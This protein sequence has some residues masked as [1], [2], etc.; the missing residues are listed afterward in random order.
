MSSGF[1]TIGVSF[2]NDAYDPGV[3]DRNLYIDR[4]SIISPPGVDKPD[5]P[6]ELVIEAEDASIRTAGGIIGG[7]WCLWS[8]GTLGEYVEIPEAGIYVVVVR[9]YGSPLDSI[10]PEMALTVDAVNEDTVTVDNAEYTDCLNS[11]IISSE[12]RGEPSAGFF[13]DRV[14]NY[15]N[16]V[17]VYIWT[18]FFCLK[19]V[20]RGLDKRLDNFFLAIKKGLRMSLKPLNLLVVTPRGLEPLFPA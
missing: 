3:E 11:P 15:L 2:L 1:H 17:Q 4:L 14:Q 16:P 10:W 5:I 7:D 6:N 18:G 13:S 12:P 19:K 8:N 20:D 9:A